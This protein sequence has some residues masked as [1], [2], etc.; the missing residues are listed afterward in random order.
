MVLESCHKTQPSTNYTVTKRNM[1]AGPFKD[2]F[3]HISTSRVLTNH[4]LEQSIE[5]GKWI[6]LVAQRPDGKTGV[7][8][9]TYVK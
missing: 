1:I 3:S 8:E 5:L 9:R 2:R 6:E 4:Q 7:R